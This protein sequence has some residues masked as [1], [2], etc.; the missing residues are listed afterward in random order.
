MGLAVL[1]GGVKKIPGEVEELHDPSE[2]RRGPWEL[3]TEPSDE[4]KLDESAG[5]PPAKL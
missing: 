1:A 5:H 3:A 2:E 4:N